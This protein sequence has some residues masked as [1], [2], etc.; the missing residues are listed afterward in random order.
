M[1]AVL[2]QSAPSVVAPQA[3][4]GDP[5][6]DAVLHEASQPQPTMMDSLKTNVLNPLARAGIKAVTGI[7]LAFADV[8]VAIA[9]SIQGK[10]NTNLPSQKYDAALDA[11]FAPP[12]ST[13]GKISE[14]ANTMIMGA[15][16]PGGGV[17]SAEEATT[18]GLNAAQQRAAEAGKELGM[19]MTPGQETGSRGL[20]QLEAKLQALPSTSAPF[21]AVGRNNQNVLNATAARAIG[22]SGSSV[23]SNVLEAANERLGSVFDSV[24]NAKNVVMTDPKTTKG[25][26]D[27]IDD[28]VAGLL[29]GNG[30][31]RDNKLVQNLEHLTSTGAVTGEQLGTL[32]SK[33]G[34]AA[35]K[36]MS[37]PSGDRDLGAALYKVKDHAD[38][39]LESSLSGPEKDTYAA[40]RQQYRSLM[41]LTS[42]T[43][44]VNPATG[45]V[46]GV[47]LASKLQQ[48]DRGGYLFGKNDSDLYNAARFA[49]AF[50]P[51]VGDSGTA[52][53]SMDLKDMALAVPGNLSTFAYLHAPVSNIVKGA[54]K[55]P[56]K[57][58]NVL[59]EGLSPRT[60]TG[61]ATGAADASEQ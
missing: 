52:T 30:T 55:L 51:I 23:D 32:S 29:P 16:L 48:S 60:L 6:M 18:S 22:E 34:R 2:S 36:Q 21:N 3:V 56:S 47:N 44:I 15:G 35:Y 24:R 7:P 38:D 17:K 20:Q 13:A 57:A 39:L 9:N 8:P 59:D 5:D 54:V 26:L 12:T 11:N 1:D 61:A 49:S 40:A 42:R 50:K 41:Q 31:I 4:T 14:I 46:S 27:S 10:P 58:K 28:D 45:N 25:I 37:S 33:L 43:G 53:R 19:K